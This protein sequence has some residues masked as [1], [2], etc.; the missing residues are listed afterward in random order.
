MKPA[1]LPTKLP[2]TELTAYQKSIVVLTGM[3]LTAAEIAL[4]LGVSWQVVK[5]RQQIIRAKMQAKNNCHMVAIY[6]QG[7][8]S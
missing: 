1:R 5:N 8:I 6:Y 2:P 3:G 7:M 4:R